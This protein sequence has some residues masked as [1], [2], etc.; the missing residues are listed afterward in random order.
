MLAKLTLIGTFSSNY[1]ERLKLKVVEG[2]ARY[3]ENK[4]LIGLI[5]V[6]ETE[7]T[8]YLVMEYASGGEVIRF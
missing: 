8:L 6:M 2:C 5:K 4:F 7:Q 3:F 1:V